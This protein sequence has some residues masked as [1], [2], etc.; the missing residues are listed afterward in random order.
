MNAAMYEEKENQQ[1]WVYRHGYGGVCV[2]CALQYVRENE[3]EC[4]IVCCLNRSSWCPSGPVR[5][6]RSRGSVRDK[7]EGVCDP[8]GSRTREG[9]RCLRSQGVKR[10]RTLSG[11][12]PNSKCFLLHNP[13]LP[14]PSWC[15]HSDI[16]SYLINLKKKK[17]PLEMTLVVW[18]CLQLCVRSPCLNVCL[19]NVSMGQLESVLMS[20]VE[21]TEDQTWLNTPVSLSPHTIKPS[22]LTQR[23]VKY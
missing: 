17:L 14:L 15:R 18:L 8:Q 22:L 16:H 20:C 23:P 1:V 13:P 7:A 4:V 11:P 10:P 12:S 2:C 19:V 6:K 9:G 3:W 5:K 21:L